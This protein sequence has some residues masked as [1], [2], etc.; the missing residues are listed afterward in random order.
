MEVSNSPWGIFFITLLSRAFLFT[1]FDRS[2]I[3][4]YEI[5]MEAQESGDN[6]AQHSNQGIHEYYEETGVC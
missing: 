5:D 1:E 6:Y 2:H 4:A 3:F